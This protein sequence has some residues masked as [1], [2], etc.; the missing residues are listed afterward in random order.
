[1]PTLDTANHPIERSRLQTVVTAI[2][3]R[4]LKLISMKL[5]LMYR[6]I[7][8]ILLS[9]SFSGLIRQIYAVLIIKSIPCT[10]WA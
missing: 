3:A 2:V 4:P 1:M 6:E 5:S 7:V 10:E 9:L 8:M